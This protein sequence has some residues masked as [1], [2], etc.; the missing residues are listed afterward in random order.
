VN[1]E[2]IVYRRVGGHDNRRAADGVAVTRFDLSRFS[3]GDL[4]DVRCGEDAPTVADDG[5]RQG[6]QILEGMKL[7][8]PS[9][10]Q[11]AAGVE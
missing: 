1:D 6:R 4:R 10:A 9:E 11:R 8:L 2:Q 5:L 3:A 7:R